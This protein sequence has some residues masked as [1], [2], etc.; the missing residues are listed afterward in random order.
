[1]QSLCIPK[2]DDMHL[3]LRD[4]EY[5]TRTV[6][7]AARQFQR[8][9]IMPNLQ[10]PI[11]TIKQAEDYYQR[12]INARGTQSTFEP[13][14][15][16]FLTEQTSAKMIKAAAAHRHIYGAKLYPA[17]A[18]THASQGV[19]H[20]KALFPVFEAMQKY[21]FPLLIHGEV[22][23]PKIDI[24]DREAR[25]IETQLMPLQNCFP[26]LNIVLEHISSQEAVDYVNAHRIAATITIHHLYY[27]RNAIFNTGINPHYYCLPILKRRSDRLALL[28]AATSGN[29]KFFLGTD[30]APH[31]IHHKE[32]ACGC[33]GIYSAYSAIELYAE[34]FEQ[35]GALD[36]LTAF[37]SHFGA[38][39]YGLARNHNTLRLEKSSW[40]IP[41]T[42]AFGRQQLTPFKSGHVISWKLVTKP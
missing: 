7:D 42:L 17:G 31:S 13:L 28:K 29:P 34:I 40:K 39:F 21:Q 6:T 10:T 36:K 24:F 9:I 12:I 27:D 25:F 19:K 14:M 26:Q 5:L 16:L 11:T 3:H 20:L 35:A 18:T 41:T 37:A 4:G 32:S 2:P 23:D 33:A 30:S 15:T 8:A 1:M 22:K 38:D